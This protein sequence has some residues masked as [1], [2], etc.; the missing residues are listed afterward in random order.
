MKALAILGKNEL[1]LT[2]RTVPE[3][4]DDEVLVRSRA[5]GICHSDYELI[6]GQYII[7][8]SYPIVPGHEWSGEVVEV[9]KM[10][11]AIRPGDR[12]VGECVIKGPD[13]MHH[14][15]FSIDGADQE[16]FRARPEWLHRL[17][18]SITFKAAA[19]IEPFTCG[20]YA[21]VR[22]G[23]T[24][25]SETVVVS[26][27][28]NIGLCTAAAAKGM[29]AR[30]ILIDPL[31]SRQDAA[32]R[33]GVDEV[34]DPSAQ[35]PVKQ[36]LELTQ[37][38]G[39]DFVVEA[40]GHDS[41]LGAVLDYAREEGRIS[42]VG[43]SLGRTIPIQFGKVQKKNLT[44]RGCIGSPGVWPAAIRF[45]DRTGLDLSPIQTHEFPLGKGEQAFVFARD[46]AHC[47]KVTLINE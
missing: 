14:F 42:M 2:D 13:R 43:I 12:V 7:P 21:L 11:K 38:A 29:G 6:S 32:R 41:S 46:P 40:S 31:A 16:F 27:G 23:G 1:K 18:D 28:G 17:P 39:A 37:G 26:G 45:L 34:I 4:S 33:L 35:D 25:A 47:I 19:L 22:N 24:N 44:L 3:I 9:G 30:V 36:V 8:F 15:G 20:F 5:V 10:V